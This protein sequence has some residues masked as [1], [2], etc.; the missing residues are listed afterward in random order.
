[1]HREGHAGPTG[2]GKTGIGDAPPAKD[3]KSRRVVIQDDD[4]MAIAPYSQSSLTDEGQD[5]EQHEDISETY[6][7]GDH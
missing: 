1:M 5:S 3:D 7:L 4:T 2:D 6:P